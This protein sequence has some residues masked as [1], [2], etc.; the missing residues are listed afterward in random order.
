MVCWAPKLG[1][2][3][4]GVSWYLGTWPCL[5]GP[6]GLSRLLF[7]CWCVP[8]ILLF[9]GLSMRGLLCGVD[10]AV[11]LLLNGWPLDCVLASVL[12]CYCICSPV[13]CCM[14]SNRMGTSVVNLPLCHLG[15]RRVLYSLVDVVRALGSWWLSLLL[16]PSDVAQVPEALLWRF[17]VLSYVDVVVLVFPTS[18]VAQ[19]GILVLVARPCWRWSLVACETLFNF[20]QCA[21]WGWMVS[22][23]VSLLLGQMPRWLTY[24]LAKGLGSSSGLGRIELCRIHVTMLSWVCRI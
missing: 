12:L 1:A 2:C 10:F 18:E 15:W 17:V 8:I 21:G 13:G 7:S 23:Y 3:T 5:S 11:G 19:G 14:C 6:D 16:S 20:I 22:G 9:C 24:M 4:L